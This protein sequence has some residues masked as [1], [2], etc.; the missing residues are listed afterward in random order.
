MAYSS[1]VELTPVDVSRDGVS[2]DKTLVAPTATHGNKFITSGRE[3]LKIVNGS[4]GDITVTLTPG[5]VVDGL[6]LPT[7][8]YTIKATGDANGLDDQVIGPFPKTWCYTGDY[9]WVVCSAVTT[10][11]MGVFRLV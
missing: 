6:T 2:A 3:Y 5:T 9:I 7:K 10:I 11:T 4:V 1:A 8:T